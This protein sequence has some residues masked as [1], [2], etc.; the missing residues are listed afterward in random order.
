[1]RI[2]EELGI[3]LDRKRASAQYCNMIHQEEIGEKQDSK[4]FKILNRKR[5]LK[6]GSL[7]P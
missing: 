3:T 4:K 7:Y 5:I 2:E 6:S 1:M